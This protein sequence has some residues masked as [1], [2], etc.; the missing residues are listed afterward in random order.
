MARWHVAQTYEGDVEADTATAASKA[1]KANLGLAP[2]SNRPDAR[3]TVLAVRKL[4][5]DFNEILVGTDLR[6]TAIERMVKEDVAI[7]EGSPC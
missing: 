6:D 3:M 4:G 7:R 1:F 5:E 2:E